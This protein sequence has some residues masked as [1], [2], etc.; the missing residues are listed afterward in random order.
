MTNPPPSFL[1]FFVCDWVTS[2]TFQ[3]MWTNGEGQTNQLSTYLD[4]IFIV[5]TLGLNDNNG[6]VYRLKK[7]GELIAITIHCRPYKRLIIINDTST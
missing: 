6:N 7:I 5:A 2:A 4:S 3:Y 1:F